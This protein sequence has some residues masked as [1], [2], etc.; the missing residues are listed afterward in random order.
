MQD[1]YCS[2]RTR[3]T[4]SHAIML[5]T[6]VRGSRPGRSDHVA[7]PVPV[8]RPDKGV[9]TIRVRYQMTDHLIQ[10]VIRSGTS[11]A[12]S[13]R[14]VVES[15]CNAR[16]GAIRLPNRG[17]S[18][19]TEYMYSY[20]TMYSYYSGSCACQASTC[21]LLFPGNRPHCDCEMRY[22]QLNCAIRAASP[23]GPVDCTC[24]VPTLHRYVS[25]P[26]FDTVV[27]RYTA[28]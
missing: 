1:S 19:D 22:R 5:V 13:T 10:S 12:Q 17:R 23:I 15:L 9:H 28:P 4:A 18:V 16:R 8:P 7:P 6:I 20:S 25:Q 3:T 2:T 21:C 27:S 26:I 24:H 11:F 14:T